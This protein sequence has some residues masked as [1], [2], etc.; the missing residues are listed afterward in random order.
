ML[1]AVSIQYHEGGR[2]G[3]SVL[4]RQLRVIVG[5]NPYGNEV[6]TDEEAYLILWIRHGIHLAAAPSLRGMVEI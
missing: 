3:H 5:M 2:P 1:C 6:V 4:F